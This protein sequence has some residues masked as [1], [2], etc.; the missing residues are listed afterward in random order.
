[1]RLTESERREAEHYL[2]LGER[3]ADAIL[4]TKAALSSVLPPIERALRMLAGP[5]SAR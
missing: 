3:V 4:D 1:V 5:G 2:A